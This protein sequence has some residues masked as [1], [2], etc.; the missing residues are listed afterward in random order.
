MT[1][2][3]VRHWHNNDNQ[4]L[5]NP[6]GGFCDCPRV[7]L[8]TIVLVE[9]DLIKSTN[10]CPWD[11]LPTN[12]DHRV[13]PTQSEHHPVHDVNWPPFHYCDQREG[14]GQLQ[15][16]WHHQS[17]VLAPYWLTQLDVQ[18]VPSNSSS[19]RH[20]YSTRRKQQHDETQL[21]TMQWAPPSP[22]RQQQ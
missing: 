11:G 14:Y 17:V 2:Q 15:F 3:D 22:P 16:D 19:L 6:N 13:E 12:L 7:L 9:H 10:T 21:P 8:M 18:H 20:L 5:A 4:S 1:N